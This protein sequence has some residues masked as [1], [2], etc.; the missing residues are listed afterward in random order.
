MLFLNKTSLIT[1]YSPFSNYLFIRNLH[2]EDTYPLDLDQDD[3]EEETT[4]QEG[5]QV[6]VDS[7]YL[8]HSKDLLRGPTDFR[9]PALRSQKI[10]KE[11]RKKIFGDVTNGPLNDA[12]GYN[13]QINPKKEGQRDFWDLGPNDIRPILEIS[14]GKFKPGACDSQEKNFPFNGFSESRCSVS[15]ENTSLCRLREFLDTEPDLV[16]CQRLQNKFAGKSIPLGKSPI[17]FQSTEFR[18]FD[19]VIQS[20]KVLCRENRRQVEDLYDRLTST[21]KDQHSC[22]MEY[23]NV[24]NF[25]IQEDSMENTMSR[26]CKHKPLRFYQ[27]FLGYCYKIDSYFF[28]G[29]QSCSARKNRLEKFKR[30]RKLRGSLYQNFIEVF[31]NQAPAQFDTS[32]APLK[33]LFVKNLNVFEMFSY[34]LSVQISTKSS[35][36]HLQNVSNKELKSTTEQFARLARDAR[37]FAD[38]NQRLRRLDLTLEFLCPFVRAVHSMNYLNFLK[39]FRSKDLTTRD[40]KHLFLYIRNGI[41]RFH[42]NRLGSLLMVSSQ[43]DIFRE[44]T[45]EYLPE[46]RLFPFLSRLIG[47]LG[48]TFK[49]FF[50]SLLRQNQKNLKESVSQFLLTE[51]AAGHSVLS[52]R[53]MSLIDPCRSRCQS[54]LQ[55]PLY[56]ILQWRISSIRCDPFF[57]SRGVLGSE[58]KATSQLRNQFLFLLSGLLDKQ[59]MGLCTDITRS[60]EERFSIIREIKFWVNQKEYYFSF[61]LFIGRDLLVFEHSS[62]DLGIATQAGVYH[63]A[64]VFVSNKAHVP[65]ILR[66][67]T[68]FSDNPD[69]EVKLAMTYRE[70]VLIPFQ[71]ERFILCKILASLKMTAWLKGPSKLSGFIEVEILAEGYT[72]LILERV[73]F[74]MNYARDLLRF[75]P[76]NRLSMETDGKDIEMINSSLDDYRRFVVHIQNTAP[77]D[78]FVENYQLVEKKH[79]IKYYE[80][81]S[82]SSFYLNDSHSHLIKRK[83]QRECHDDQ[84]ASETPKPVQSSVKNTHFKH[85]RVYDPNQTFLFEEKQIRVDRKSEKHFLTIDQVKARDSES[86]RRALVFSFQ[87]LNSY[88]TTKLEFLHQRLDCTKFET[89]SRSKPS[90]QTSNCFAGLEV[91]FGYFSV[92]VMVS[93]TRVAVDA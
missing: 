59:D 61:P 31:A 27:N 71:K 84:C 9:D 85:L 54:P 37:H 46:K 91:N 34:K 63:V 23:L 11:F 18:L 49:K 25:Q 15:G 2:A 33:A 79:L 80:F 69:F 81:A 47:E 76:S 60:R 86:Q 38:F 36:E 89:V 75:T 62:L 7:L 82:I 40:I 77:F 87:Y 5:F 51:I 26:D 32:I 66:R 48:F 21:Y 30:S 6:R 58:P 39:D 73:H 88:M 56:S 19:E 14:N 93:L 65:I 57:Q 72:G 22:G 4:P 24:A 78:L 12:K 74:R 41:V 17:D 1:P 53:F 3:E 13:Y 28:S 52:K 55:W 29:K 67:M 43:F 35:K 50:L 64:D 8:E 10:T 92:H 45:P 42:R 68:L 20:I 90:P 83:N 70:H 44:S 16:E